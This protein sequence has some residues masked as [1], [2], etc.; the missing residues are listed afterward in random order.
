MTIVTGFICTHTPF[1]RL[2]SRYCNKL[3]LRRRLLWAAGA[4]TRADPLAALSGS[5]KM[6]HRALRLI[7][8]SLQGA[9]TEQAPRGNQS[10]MLACLSIVPE[11][12]AYVKPMMTCQLGRVRLQKTYHTYTEIMPC[13][14]VHLTTLLAAYLSGAGSFIHEGKTLNRRCH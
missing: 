7:F 6:G 5:M 1:N 8:R 10:V 11:C 4:G 9:R 2:R 3:P 14:R 13:R 12:L